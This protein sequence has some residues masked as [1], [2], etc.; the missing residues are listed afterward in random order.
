M[1]L[2]QGGLPLTVSDPAFESKR[3]NTHPGM[4]HFAASGPAGKSC[5]ECEHWTGCG[6]EKG[7]YAKNGKHG[8][9]LKPRACAKYRELMGGEIGPAIPYTAMSCKYF[10]QAAEPPSITYKSID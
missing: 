9:V 1:G 3:N 10:A 4:A 7:H 6:L 2:I 8:G 5:R